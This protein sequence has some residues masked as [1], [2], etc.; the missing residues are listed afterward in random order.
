MLDPGAG[1]PAQHK[2]ARIPPD[3]AWMPTAQTCMA[4]G[5]EQRHFGMPCAVRS[6]ARVQESRL[7]SPS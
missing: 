6:F 3:T 1:T 7:T 4:H 2:N 5:Y